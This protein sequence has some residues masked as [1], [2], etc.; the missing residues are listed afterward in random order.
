MMIDDQWVSEAV[1]A[2]FLKYY[3]EYN[4]AKGVYERTRQM[5]RRIKVGGLHKTSNVWMQFMLQ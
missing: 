1:Y 3:Y 5:K 2:F 4:L